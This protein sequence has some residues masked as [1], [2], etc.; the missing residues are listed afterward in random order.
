MN[1]SPMSTSASSLGNVPQSIPAGRPRAT[2]SENAITI[3]FGLWMIAGLFIDGYAHANMR[4]T[5]ESFFT[6]WHGI[7]YSGFASAALWTTWLG[8]KQARLGRRGLEAIPVGYELGMVGVIVFGLG[9]FGDMI[10]HTVFGIEVNIAALL[11]PSH[12]MLLIG[13][14]LVLT[15]PLRSAWA[16]LPHKPGFLEFL[17]ALISSTTA[18]TTVA[19]FNMH[20]WALGRLPDARDWM[21]FVDNQALIM[22]LA[23]TL[24]TNAILTTG[25]LF[26]VRRWQTPFGTFTI[27]FGFTALCMGLLNGRVNSEFVAAVI[28]GLIVDALAL[29]LRPTITRVWALRAFAALVP[30]TIWG[31][32]DLHNQ[33]FRGGINL[34]VEFWTGLLV[35]SVLSGLALS[36]LV[37]PPSVPAHLEPRVEPAGD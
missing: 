4:S 15:S 31:I 17:P 9:G 21:Q 2:P 30:L 26:M 37:V 6:P 35:M 32:H 10:W 34:E 24:F 27:M 3:V 11:S 29:W 25:V 18:L 20:Q 19:F 28:T 1:T 22:I 14:V 5:I 7:L 12:L 8:Y 16:T 13:G 36:V 33:F 23:A